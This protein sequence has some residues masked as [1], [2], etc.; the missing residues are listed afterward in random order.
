MKGKKLILLSFAIGIIHYGVQFIG[1]SFAEGNTANEMHGFAT[2]IWPIMSFPLFFIFPKTSL[3]N[4]F[5]LMLLINSS[6][7]VAMI[8]ILLIFLPKKRAV[9]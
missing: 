2:C 1:W 8:N 4:F 6:L 3:N 7:W 9:E 5:F